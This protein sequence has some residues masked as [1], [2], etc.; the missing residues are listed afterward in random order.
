[1]SAHIPANE[2]TKGWVAMAVSLPGPVRGRLLHPLVRVNG[3]FRRAS[4]EEALE[5]SAEGFRSIVDRHGPDALGCFSCSKATDELN[6][7]AQKF[8]RT[9]VGTNNIDSCQRT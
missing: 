2:P 9:V 1:M 6:Y 5:R 4:W 7:L 8:M 3:A